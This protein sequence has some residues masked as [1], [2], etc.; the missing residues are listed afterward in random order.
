MATY[1]ATVQIGRYVERTSRTP[2]VP[3]SV[4]LPEARLAGLQDAFGRQPEMLALFERLFGPYPFA[5]YTVVVTDDELEIPLEA[6][7]LSTFGSNF[8]TDDWDSVRLVAHELSHQW[9]GNSLTV[10]AWRDIWLHEGF[11]CYCEWLWS[12]ESGGPTADDTRPRALGAPARTCRRTSLLGDPGPDDMFDDRVYK[13]GALLLHA[14]RRTVGDEPFFRMLR[15]WADRHRHG[16]VTTEMFVALA[17]E[18]AGRGPRRRLRR[19][20]QPDRASATAWMTPPR[21]PVDVVSTVTRGLVARPEIEVA[22]PRRT[23]VRDRPCRRARARDRRPSATPRRA[24]TDGW[25]R[26]GQL[27]S[28]PSTSRGRAAPDDSTSTPTGPASVSATTARP[29]HRA[30]LRCTSG[31]ARRPR[32]AMAGRGRSSRTSGSGAG[33]GR[34]GSPTP[35]STDGQADEVVHRTG[36]GSRVVDDDEP[37]G[38][39][40]GVTVRLRGSRARGGRG[41]RA[42]V[43]PLAGRCTWSVGLTGACWSCRRSLPSRPP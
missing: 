8:L 34:R 24:P 22:R 6:Q 28:T 17:A 2:S 7:G 10:A 43:G 42:G 30:T 25:R 27:P 20:A 19:L 37:P 35:S 29:G 21:D 40:H 26:L 31:S 12:E 9:F 13:R 32:P 3:M 1:L 18:V 33:P 36:S 23:G 5:R 16:T 38:R 14:L 41:L 11:A 39:G 15:T 4:V